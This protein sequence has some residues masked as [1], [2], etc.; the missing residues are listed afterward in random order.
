MAIS[1][2]K[3]NMYD[4]VS[5]TH[6]HLRGKC[7][8]GCKY[9]YVQ[10]ME[11]RYGGGHY[12]GELRL[13]EKEFQ[14]SY[15]TPTIR[16][17][18]L[19]A[20]FDHPIFFIEH[21]NDI[22]CAPRTWALRIYEQCRKFDDCE[23]VFQSKRPSEL[24]RLQYAF[25]SR[26]MIGT[27]VE[28]DTVPHELYDIDHLPQTPKE[29]LA[30]LKNWKGVRKFITIEPILRMHNPTEFALAIA[31]AEPS[32]V[33]IGADSKGTGL[34]EPSKEQVLELIDAL[35]ANGVTINKKS[36]LERLLKDKTADKGAVK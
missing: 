13:S 2:A 8:H 15:D 7:S 23:Y 29:R 16:R 26:F 27:T 9:C 3:G 32:F 14:C 31:D 30:V 1:R 28:S 12:A 10:A 11:A 19:E 21:C 4:F 25:P 36:N 18:A 20:G 34:P 35:K 22:G 24:N 5:H 17:E 6:T 33:N